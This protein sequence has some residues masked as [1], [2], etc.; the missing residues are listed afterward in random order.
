MFILATRPQ[1]EAI[2][3]GDNLMIRRS[4]HTFTTFAAAAGRIDTRQ[5]LVANA[6]MWACLDNLD[7]QS[8]T[9]GSGRLQ[10]LD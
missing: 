4:E 9:N 3:F 10:Q 6:A 2:F 7:Y 1:C 8:K 5:C